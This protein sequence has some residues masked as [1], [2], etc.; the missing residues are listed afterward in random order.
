M[1]SRVLKTL[2]VPVA[3]AASLAVA[4]CPH[5]W[6]SFESVPRDAPAEAGA[7]DVNAPEG[8]DSPFE[9]GPTESAVFATMTEKPTVLAADAAGIVFLTVQGSVLSCPHEGCALPGIIASNQKDARS[10]A[11][12]YGF[13][14]WTSR[15]DNTVRRAS[16]IPGLGPAEQAVD[17]DVPD[18]VALTATKLVFSVIAANNLIR[19]AGLR[20]CTPGVD[21]QF[22]AP[23]FNTF[24]D[25]NVTVVKLDSA[26]AYW[27]DPKNNVVVGCPIATCESDS[28][29]ASVLA[30]E[31]VLPF[32]LAVDADQIYF[33]STLEGGSVRAVHRGPPAGDA[34]AG[35]RALAKAVGTPAY[36]AV[37]KSSVWFT[38]PAGLVTRVPRNGGAAVAVATGL[39][40]PTGIAI[41]GGWVY[42]AC[43]GDGRI[44]RWKAD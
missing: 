30:R 5:D 35:P 16:R 22:S 27:L 9:S 1:A 13:V 33:G 11:I 42:V 41:G 40:Q 38:D 12:G 29:K 25:G 34:G 43:A 31:P 44:L 6:A 21:C 17:P 28:T 14:A 3:A 24:A 18:A 36:L 23:S 32:A 20:T 39:A 10:L 26:D 4:G 15:G 37:T 7:A 8:S 19:S 2:L